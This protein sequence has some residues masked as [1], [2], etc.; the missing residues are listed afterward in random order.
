M[1]ETTIPVIVAEDAAARVAGLGL[2]REFEQ[3][4]EHAKRTAPG[5]RAIRVTLEY[6]PVC[7]SNEPQVVIQVHRHDLSSEEAWTDQTD[8][9][10]GGWQVTTFPPEVCQHFVMSSVY[11]GPDEW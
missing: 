8:W 2:R 1:A 4:I 9:D 10:W 3:M 7:P 11:G 6:D 5:L